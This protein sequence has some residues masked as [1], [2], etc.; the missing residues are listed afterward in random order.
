M[1]KLGK[2]FIRIII[3]G[4]AFSL[5]SC[6]RAPIR[7]PEYPLKDTISRIPSTIL[8]KSVIHKV[9]LGETVWRIAKMYDVSTKDITRA[10]NLESSKEIE[11][12]QR[13]LIPDAAPI[14]PIITF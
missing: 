1:K 12:G 8:R 9:A 5:C 4:L 2:Y 6:T 11:M 13:L 10:N 7:S 3:V 14:K